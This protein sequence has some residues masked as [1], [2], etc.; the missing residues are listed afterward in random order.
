MAGK[1]SFDKPTLVLLHG[2]GVN[3]GVWQAV[4]PQLAQQVQLIT[5]D[6]PGFGLNRQHPTPYQL[7]AV[8]EQIAQQIPLHS[9]VCG[10]SLGGVVAIALAR[11]YPEKVQQLGLI[12]ASPCFIAEPGW[13]GMAVE[14][15]QQFARALSDN[16][17]QTIERFLAI[18]AM[19]SSSVRQDIKAIK[20]AIMA[21][22]IAETSAIAGALQ[23]LQCDLR[24]EFAALHQ[25]IAGYYGRLDSL[26]PVNVLEQ[27]QLLQPQAKFTVAAQ[28][29]HAPFISHSAEFSAWLQSWL[30]LPVL[31]KP[32]R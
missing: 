16:I 29:S 28:A 9:Y 20:Q 1:M 6:L 3:Q 15:M 12:A 7:D 22:P 32:E 26:V 4:T 19:G 13:P 8:V 11:R 24:A 17:A 27:L 5:P 14:V 18:Q 31:P 23:L 30:S 21:Y 2:W 10:W 25:P